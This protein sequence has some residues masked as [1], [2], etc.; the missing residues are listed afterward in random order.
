MYGWQCDLKDRSRSGIESPSALLFDV[1]YRFSKALKW[2]NI[3][4]HM[5]HVILPPRRSPAHSGFMSWVIETLHTFWLKLPT[6]MRLQTYK[7]LRSAGSIIYGTT[8]MEVQRIPFGMYLKYGPGTHSDRYAKEF[9][10]LRPVRNETSIPIPRPIDLIVSPIESILVTSRLEGNPAGFGTQ[11]YSDQELETMAQDLREWIA[12]LHRV[13]RSD[14]INAAIMNA[15]GGPCLDY[16]IGGS[17]VGPYSSEKEFSK[18]LSLGILPDLVHRNDHNIVFTHS[19]LNMRNILVKDGR[20]SR[21][22][23][24]ENAGWYLE[25]WEYTKCHFG[26]RL[27]HRWLKM[28]DS[29]FGD[30]FHE[31]LRIERQYWDYTSPF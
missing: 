12:Q 23:D 6:I 22:V 11:A 7:L 13:P 21:I 18:S 2:N 10:A 16:R 25:Y 24:W 28:V 9:S 29:V 15:S 3:S 5:R 1:H 14:S 4:N 30:T 17:P 26:A 19:D 20:I 31:E 27:T 8:T